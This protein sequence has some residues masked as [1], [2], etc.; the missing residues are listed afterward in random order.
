MSTCRHMVTSIPFSVVA[1]MIIA[2]ESFGGFMWPGVSTMAFF[3]QKGLVCAVTVFRKTIADVADGIF[4]TQFWYWFAASLVTKP[5]TSWLEMI[6]G[7]ITRL[8][9]PAAGVRATRKVLRNPVSR[10]VIGWTSFTPAI[11]NASP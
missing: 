6:G 7:E 9:E 11:V 3:A 8:L 4:T 1:D 5:F 10:W 2:P